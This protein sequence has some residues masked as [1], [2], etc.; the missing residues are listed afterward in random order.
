MAITV[1]MLAVLPLLMAGGLPSSGGAESIS[2]PAIPPTLPASERDLSL[3]PSDTFRECD[4]CPEMIV[5][6]AGT[7]VMGSAASELG[8]HLNEAPQHDVK[9]ASPFAV[10]RFAVTF[11]EWDACVND[12][13]CLRYKN[14]D[15]GWGRGRRPVIDHSWYEI[16]EFLKWISRKTGKQYRL[17]TEAERE[18]VTRAGTVTA[19]WWGNSI[20]ISE[21]N[22]DGS[23]TYGKGIKAIRRGRTVPV[24]SFAPNPWG[25]Y[26]VHG[27]VWE[28]TQDCY[29]D[30]YRGAPADGA[31]W[32][33]GNCGRR[34]IR[35]GSWYDNPAALRAGNRD[36]NVTGGRSVGIGF[37]VARSL[38][39]P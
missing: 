21:A 3:H 33:S 7:F 38:Q 17:L 15:Q 25:L 16:Q 24:D 23:L 28:W 35:G 14:A 29:H 27:N 19:F 37:R 5:V 31:A 13:D 12:H 6:P 1:A 36:A 4:K 8:H 10:G 26:Q 22:Y 18:Y 20:S 30:N 34:V 39:A 32:T 2:A 11:D 9:F